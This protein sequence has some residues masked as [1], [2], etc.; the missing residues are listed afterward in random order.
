[1]AEQGLSRAAEAVS[2]RCAAVWASVNEEALAVA[3]DNVRK[4][5]AGAFAAQEARYN[6]LVAQIRR[7][8]DF[9]GYLAKATGRYVA[10]AQSTS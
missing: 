6:G 2:Q 8:K 9:R 4:N 5:H 10:V 3:A 1:M 7:D